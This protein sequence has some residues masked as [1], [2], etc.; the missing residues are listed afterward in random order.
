[1]ISLSKPPE[2][3]KDSA[4]ELLPLLEGLSFIQ[5]ADLEP[6]DYLEICKC[7]KLEKIDRHRRLFNCDDKADKFYIIV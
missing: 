7:I 5:N 6:S 4:I 3:R 2:D 1:M